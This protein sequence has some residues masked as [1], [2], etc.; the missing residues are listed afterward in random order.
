MFLSDPHAPRMTIGVAVIYLSAIYLINLGWAP[1]AFF[2]GIAILA[3]IF[4]WWLM[5][6][7]EGWWPFKRQ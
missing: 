6:Y 3:A 2:T 7:L 4:S 5:A 1:G